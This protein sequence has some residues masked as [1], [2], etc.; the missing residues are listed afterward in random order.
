MLGIMI[1]KSIGENREVVVNLS[2]GSQEG[3]LENIVL[4]LRFEG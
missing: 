1:E 3:F 2:G 4:K